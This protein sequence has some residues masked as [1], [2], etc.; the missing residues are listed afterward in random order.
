MAITYE[1]NTATFASV[2]YEDEVVSFRDFLQGS[3]PDEL[4]LNFNE[5]EDVHLAVLQLIMAYKKNYSVSYE[6]GDSKKLF[7]QVLEGFDTSENHCN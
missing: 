3:S 4:K 7:Q 1:K 2:I 5:C 6:F